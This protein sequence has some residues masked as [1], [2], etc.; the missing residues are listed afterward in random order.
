MESVQ[1]ISQQYVL[2][3]LQECIVEFNWLVA[4]SIL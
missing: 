3:D 1:F 4:S 2:V